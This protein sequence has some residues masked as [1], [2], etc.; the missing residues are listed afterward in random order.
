[1]TE[2]QRAREYVL[3]DERQ[4][5]GVVYDIDLS[6][7]GKERSTKARPLDKTPSITLAKRGVLVSGEHVRQGER[8]QKPVEHIYRDTMTPALAPIAEKRFAYAEMPDG[9]VALQGMEQTTRP[10]GM[11][12]RQRISRQFRSD[13][14][15]DEDVLFVNGDIS[16]KRTYGDVRG[17]QL[18]LL[19]DDRYDGM[20][21]V[22]QRI[23][24]T[25]KE[26][27]DIWHAQ[28]TRYNHDGEEVGRRRPTMV[29]KEPP[30]L[31]GVQSDLP[32]VETLELPTW[33]PP[34]AEDWTKMD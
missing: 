25:R 24:Y 14:T 12:T 8:Q 23:V 16:A 34:E 3:E 33:T 26:G 15:A 20:G 7:F 10:H 13:G 1:M 4:E 9:T 28:T 11:E 19:Y 2:M 18:R 32:F 31:T 30:G 27:E 21:R 5:K 29:G 6:K 17:D 22:Q